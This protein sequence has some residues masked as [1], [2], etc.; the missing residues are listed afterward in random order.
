[1]TYRKVRWHDRKTL[2]YRTHI[3]F[4]DAN[5]RMRQSATSYAGGESGD[6]S[7]LNMNDQVEDH[8][9][10]RRSIV[11]RSLSS[12]RMG[13]RNNRALHPRTQEVFQQA[14]LYVS[15][16]YFTHVWST[17]TRII[18]QLHPGRVYFQLAVVHSFCDPL[19]GFLNFLVYQR[20]RFRRIREHHPELSYFQVVRRVLRFSF[21]PPLDKLDITA[22]TNRSSCSRCDVGASQGFS[23]TNQ[24]GHQSGPYGF[25]M[26]ED[27]NPN[28]DYDH[29]IAKPTVVNFNIAEEYADEDG[30]CNSH[31]SSNDGNLPP[32]IKPVIL[33]GSKDVD[34]IQDIAKVDVD[35]DEENKNIRNADMGNVFVNVMNNDAPSSIGS[36]AVS[37]DEDDETDPRFL[38]I[39]RHAGDKS[40]EFKAEI[41]QSRVARI[42]RQFHA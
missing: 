41:E 1:M 7:K 42:Q 31:Q 21:L 24:D 6:L 8:S 5:G 11:S 14:M 37:D 10:S 25:T 34:T 15:A 20:P 27:G 39:G 30:D 17:T 12:V 26:E 16:F 35:N 33:D 28:T 19:Q 32:Y 9:V 4:T 38:S 23:F 13:S 2:Q 40:E 22:R 29:A 36:N 3:S 18:Q